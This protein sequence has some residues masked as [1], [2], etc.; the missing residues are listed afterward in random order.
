MD[1]LRQDFEKIQPVLTIWDTFSSL[2]TG[3]DEN[4]NGDV[5]DVIRLIKG[6]G[7]A[8]HTASL[9]I[10]HYGKDTDRGLRGAA[11]FKNNVD[12]TWEM[13]RVPD[14]MLSVLSCIKTKDGENFEPIMMM[15]HVVD[16]GMLRQ[17]GKPT[18]SLVLKP[19]NEKPPVKIKSLN[20]KN[21]QILA[22]L[23]KAVND[24]GVPPLPEIIKRYKGNAQECPQ[25]VLKMDD[26]RTVA[27]PL[28]NGPQNS[29][30]TGF[31]RSIS[32][33]EKQGKIICYAD[34]LWPIS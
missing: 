8:G 33:L 29:K 5:A 26:F 19:T 4:S 1:D 28:I 24:N 34:Y 2:A 21:T 9:A 18:T 17:N 12:F 16:L 25:K 13:T 31:S 7:I 20:S 3:M 10:H 6:T 27:Y 23:F 14:T 30:R 22:E 15:A 32:E 11:A